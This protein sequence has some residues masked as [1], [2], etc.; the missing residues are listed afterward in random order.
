[1]R[2]RKMSNEW[3]KAR[4]EGCGL[5][6][7]EAARLTRI[8]AALLA[9]LE[10]GWTTGPQIALDIA[11][12]YG[13]PPEELE[14][15]TCRETLER[16][17]RERKPGMRAWKAYMSRTAEEVRNSPI[18]KAGERKKAARDAA[19]AGRA[20]R[21]GLARQSTAKARPQTPEAAE[22]ADSTCKP[23]QKPVQES[24]SGTE[25]II[26]PEGGCAYRNASGTIYKVM[27]TGEGIYQIMK[28]SMHERRR[29][30]QA[31]STKMHDTREAADRQ[32]RMH[33]ALYGMTRIQEKESEAR[34][35]GT[36]ENRG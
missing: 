36:Q 8:S 25:K 12:A 32:L 19:C 2:E 26:L 7:G 6:I 21:R 5:T 22:H 18:D 29:G 1:M 23:Q 35:S 15:I 24:S 14:R 34:A 33:A 9:G 27:P 20:V 30:W 16:H 13:M 17:R 31:A 11:K 28:R 3:M 4:R 10:G